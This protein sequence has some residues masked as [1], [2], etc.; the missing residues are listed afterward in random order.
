VRGAGRDTWRIDPG[1]AWQLT[2]SQAINPTSPDREGQLPG[3]SAAPALTAR[4]IVVRLDQAQILNGA[5]LEVATGE[6]HALI[7]P[8]GAGKT[9]LANVLTGHV[10]PV[11]GTV[12]LYG[13]TLTGS[14][15][16]RVRRGIGRK[17]Q[18][19]RV[20]PR[21][22]SEENLELAQARS[23]SGG[24]SGAALDIGEVRFVLGE[25][26]SHGWRQ[27]LEMMMVSSQ[28]PHVAV[29]DEPT[30][31]M[32][33]GE[34]GEL[35]EMILSRR[36]TVTYLVVEHDMDF[37]RTVADRVS[38]MH[39]GQVTATGSFQEIEAN[40]TVRQIYLGEPAEGTLDGEV[41][42]LP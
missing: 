11:S 12:E 2:E 39:E 10:K 25:V 13:E 7:G 3:A 23:A 21:I 15:W 24:D 28:Q 19:P 14:T 38:F 42:S 27:K 41:E 36:G 31:G 4:D 30:A 18:I 32:T 9:T 17:F 26:L 8:N 34:R 37:V 5:S 40:S 35:A 1:G 20:F 16:R 6:I 33:K 22:T 29:L